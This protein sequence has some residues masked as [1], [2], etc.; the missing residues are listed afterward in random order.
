MPSRVGS[1][2]TLLLHLPHFA[3]H[4]VLL[5]HLVHALMD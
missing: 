2:P 4:A 3:E 1:S 5:W